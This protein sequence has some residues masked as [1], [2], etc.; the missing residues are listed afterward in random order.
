MTQHV[1]ATEAV[2]LIQDIYPEISGTQVRVILDQVIARIID[3]DEII[4]NLNQIAKDA[5]DSET[6]SCTHCNHD[7]GH[8]H[9]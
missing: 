5:F 2:K 4:T 8:H 1:L 6:A 3:L 9:V 7:E